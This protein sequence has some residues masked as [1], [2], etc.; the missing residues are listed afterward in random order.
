VPAARAAVPRSA[1]RDRHRIGL[2]LLAVV[3]AGIAI[4]AGIGLLSRGSSRPGTAIVSS[5]Y[6]MDGMASWA[7]GARLAPAI[8]TLIDQHGRRFSLG[9]LHGRTVALVFFDSHCTSECPLEG[10]EL[11]A[12]ESALPRAQR[13]VLVA[14]SVNAAD[15]RASA[16]RAI[17]KW[18]LAAVAPWYWLM[19]PRKKLAP[20][21][22]AYH[23][24]VGPKVNGDIAHT[25]A[26]YLIDRH[27]YERSGYLYPFGERFLS[28][29]LR[30]LARDRKA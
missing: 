5:R 16:A 3:F 14:V 20:V 30:V 11:A 12:T 1:R 6:G 8:S 28:H 23:I 17:R 21:W 7:A 29:D 27:G 26:L 19:G 13:P 18:G 2:W 22:G 4:G 9:S 24:F 10:R 25:E 15:T